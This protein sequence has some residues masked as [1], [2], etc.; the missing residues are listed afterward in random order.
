MPNN[1]SKVSV[2]VGTACFC[3]GVLLGLYLPTPT[4]FLRL[5]HGPDSWTPV[6]N[7]LQLVI[8]SVPTLLIAWLSFR[9]AQTVA[10]RNSLNSK[11]R[12]IYKKWLND[13]SKIRMQCVFASSTHD[14]FRTQYRSHKK[15]DAVD[16]MEKTRAESIEQS[17][18]LLEAL[19]DL[20]AYNKKLS[21]FCSQESVD[22]ADTGF[23][24][25]GELVIVYCSEF[26][27]DDALFADQCVRRKKVGFKVDAI[28]EVFSGIAK[29]ELGVPRLSKEIAW[30]TKREEKVKPFNEAVFLAAVALCLPDTPTET[31][32]S[33]LPK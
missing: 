14:S 33:S 26:Q 11:Q 16:A 2:I 31:V 24:A 7:G 23:A 27:I 18:A 10:L 4:A 15:G 12:E 13:A 8:I 21:V 5:P 30:F 22:A 29:K 17:I 1:I 6:L 25:L 3:A 28:I 32:C 19:R 9:F 20:F